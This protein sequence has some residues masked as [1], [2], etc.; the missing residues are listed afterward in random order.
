MNNDNTPH[1]ENPIDTATKDATTS[2]IPKKTASRPRSSGR[3]LYITAIVLGIILVLLL[4]L[5]IF[6]SLTYK[7]PTHSSIVPSPPI[8]QISKS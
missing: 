5:Y 4:A 8:I 3:G 6:L 1:E 2:P 7:K